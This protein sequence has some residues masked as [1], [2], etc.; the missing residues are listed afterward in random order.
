MSQPKSREA[1]ITEQAFIDISALAE[2]AFFSG[3]KVNDEIKAILKYVWE[4]G[5]NRGAY[6][7]L[8]E[9]WKNQG[10]S[11]EQG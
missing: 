10:G 9:G 2:A 3:K 4:E 6:D 5:Y 7:M 8:A 1:Q 11:N